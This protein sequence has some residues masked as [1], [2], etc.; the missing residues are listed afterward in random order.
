ME[1][2]IERGGGASTGVVEKRSILRR[3]DENGNKCADQ[4]QGC[5]RVIRSGEEI[6]VHSE[7]ALRL[8]IMVN[9]DGV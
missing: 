7:I 3:V 2:G 5:A 8:H 4:C 1:H 9:C 6:Q